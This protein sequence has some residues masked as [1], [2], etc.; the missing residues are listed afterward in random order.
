[1]TKI[2]VIINNKFIIFSKLKKLSTSPFNSG[3]NIKTLYM[4][5]LDEGLIRN[6]EETI[7]QKLTFIIKKYKIDWMLINDLD[8]AELALKLTKK[9]ENIK[10][11]TFLEDK[12]LSYAIT[13]QLLENKHLENVYCYNIPQVMYNQFYSCNIETRCDFSFQSRFM[14]YNGINSYA[15]MYQKE[16]LKIKGELTSKEAQDLER[17]LKLNLRVNV[18]EIYQYNKNALNLL[19]CV[20][21]KLKINRV[22][23]HIVEDSENTEL[24][25]NDIDYITELS[26]SVD[27]DIKVKYSNEYRERNKLKQ[28]NLTIFKYCSLGIAIVSTIFIVIFYYKDFKSKDSLKENMN[29]ITEVTG[30]IENAENI[31]GENIGYEVEVEEPE[32]PSKGYVSPYKKLY[33]D[34][35]SD[36]ILLNDDTIGW[37]KVNNT[38]INYPVVQASDNDYYLKHA[39]DKTKNKAGWLFADYRNNFNDLSDNTIIYGHTMKSG[40]IFGTLQNVLNPD[41]YSNEQNLEITFNVKDNS[42][43]WQIFSVYIIDN[44]NDYLVS[45]FTTKESFMN[46]IEMFKSRSIKDFGVTVDGNDNILTLST[47]Y[48]VGAKQ[49]VVVH[50]VKLN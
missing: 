14:Q 6:N 21:T 40:H 43:K 30:A 15:N 47:C 10:N 24:I 8:I 34:I 48:G 46:Y 33:S 45:D 49:R 2:K 37:L 7:L 27:F 38:K 41:W 19:I 44:T 17:I 3:K 28:I 12:E 31:D 39:F 26:K 25:L 1:M 35:Y 11:V 18:I 32:N 42:Y 13:S 9:I 36:L 22:S 29:K 20:L 4:T 16:V 5:E 50:A 23:V